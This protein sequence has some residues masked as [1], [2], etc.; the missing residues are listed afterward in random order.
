MGTYWEIAERPENKAK[1]EE[2]RPKVDKAIRE[3]LLL[4]EFFA[5][6]NIDREQWY[7]IRPKEFNYATVQ[8]KVLGKAVR[9]PLGGRLI[10]KE[11]WINL[12]ELQRAEQEELLRK[13]DE[14]RER[15]NKRLR[16]LKK[17]N[18]KTQKELYQR[19]NV[20]SI[21]E[22]EEK[23]IMPLHLV[24]ERE[25]LANQ[26]REQVKP[27]QEIPVEQKPVAPKPPV[28]KYGRPIRFT[29]DIPPETDPAVVRKILKAT[30][31]E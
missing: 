31:G 24:F 18:C 6:E 25:K 2:L 27:K 4:S 11:Q 14:K 26:A 12:S 1:W 28:T 8:K 16:I 13:R 10:P 9:K 29:L 20:K 23:K 21:E 15:D 17:Y 7:R 30:F 3:G 19:Y 5:Q 22:L